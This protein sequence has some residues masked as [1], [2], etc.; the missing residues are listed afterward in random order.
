MFKKIILNN[1]LRILTAPMKGTN[2]VTTLVVVGTGS[3]YETKRNN[4]VSHFLEHMVFKGTKKR[5]KPLD[6]KRELD[7]IG[8]ISNAFTSHE[9]TGYFIKAGRIH[10]DFS[11]DLLSDIYKNSLLKEKELKRERQVIIEEIHRYKDTPTSFIWRMWERL[12]YGNQPAGWEVAGTEDILKK[13]K[14]SDFVTYWSNHYVSTN[15]A[16]IVA[17]NFEEKET[18]EKI[19]KYFSGIRTAKTGNPPKVRESQK[20]PE[21]EI[22]YKETDQTHIVLGFRGLPVGHKDIYALQ[23]LATITGGNW[24]SRMFETIREKLGLAYTVRTAEE[25]FSNRGYFVTYAGVDHSYAKKTISAI[26]G[27]YN[28]LRKNGVT[29]KELKLAKDYIKGTS[30]IGMEASDAVADFIGIEEI[31]TGKPLTVDE[32]FGKIDRVTVNDVNRMARFIFRPSSLNLALLGPYKD[33]KEF[34]KNLKL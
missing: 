3:D 26:L 27:E 15:T 11:L 12:L 31:V 13:L 25:S 20:K 16:V 10:L 34:E 17:G 29:A 32:V 5:P 4:G 23:V 24:S 30:L 2:T 22:E 28:K 19:K 9:F 33:G 8:S 7:S 21:L 18:V 14:R 1:G 6:I